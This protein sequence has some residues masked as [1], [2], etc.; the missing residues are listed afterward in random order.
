M[1][2][3]KE[4]TLD[5]VLAITAIPVTKISTASA[6]SAALALTPTISHDFTQYF[7]AD[8]IAIGQA[9]VTKNGA[10]IGSLIPIMR[11]TGKAKDDEG[12]SVVGRL[13]T[14]TVNCQVDDRDS[15][16]W[17]NLL[18]LERTP[19][20]LLLTFRDLSQAFV[21]ATRD[22]Y[23]CTTDRDGGKTSVQFRIQNLMGIQMLV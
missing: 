18:T 8:T 1:T 10:P 7:D 14:V 21:S 23:L 5:D 2:T 13:H 15:T 22:S 12:D 16:I 11:L 4:F 6:T 20:H 17:D 19:S 9:K 3:C